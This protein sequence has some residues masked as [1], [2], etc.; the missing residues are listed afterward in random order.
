[1]STGRLIPFDA[2]KSGGTVRFERLRN[3][4][5]I[6]SEWSIRMPMVMSSTDVP[7]YRLKGYRE[8]GGVATVLSSL[9]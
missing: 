5:W 3:E 4:Q 1:V 9:R 8:V 6:V 2:T 7:G